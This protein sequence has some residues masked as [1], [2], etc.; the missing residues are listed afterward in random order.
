[1]KG[2]HGFASWD[3]TYVH[4]KHNPKDRVVLEY[5]I[6]GSVKEPWTWVRTQGKG[7]VFYTAL[8]HRDELWQKDE[9][10][11]AHVLGGLR[12][13]LGLENGGAAPSAK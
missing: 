10:F 1:M 6:D 13:V 3:E 11:K 8:G 4:H 2:Y 12:Y 7:R 5:R 9:R